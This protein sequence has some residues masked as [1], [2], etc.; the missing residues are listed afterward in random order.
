MTSSD[1]EH[2]EG[3]RGGAVEAVAMLTDQTQIRS[4]QRTYPATLR[5]RRML[6]DVASPQTAGADGWG[7]GWESGRRQSGS[8]LG[9]AGPTFL[10]WPGT[11]RE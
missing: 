4:I 9:A 8:L 10:L 6:A 7:C 5:G 1:R 11:A 3:V 2:A